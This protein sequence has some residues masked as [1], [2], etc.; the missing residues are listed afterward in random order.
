ML[1]I[2]RL[3]TYTNVAHIKNQKD[4]NLL[5]D[6]GL[7]V[8]LSKYLISTFV[9]YKR[10]SILIPPGGLLTFRLRAGSFVPSAI[11]ENKF[12]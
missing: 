3:N 9:Q 1:L 2:S 12:P 10:M 7:K 6:Y 5:K 11:S 8:V 4:L